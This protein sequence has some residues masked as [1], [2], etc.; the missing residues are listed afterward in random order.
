MYN[1]NI[2]PYI[3]VVLVF[4]ESSA[5]QANCQLIGA[6]QHR[7]KSI[8]N[9]ANEILK[10]SAPQEELNQFEGKVNITLQQWDDVCSMVRLYLE[11]VYLF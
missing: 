6:K 5:L 4:N 8:Q 1:S 10:L 3:F 7:V 2:I 9:L 11:C